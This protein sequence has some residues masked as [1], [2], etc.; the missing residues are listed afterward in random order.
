MPSN[1]LIESSPPQGVLI[2]WIVRGAVVSIL[3]ITLG[4]GKPFNVKQQPELPPVSYAARAST[5][6]VSIQ[7]QAIADEDFLYDTFD[8]NLISAGVLP[9]RVMLT[10]SVDHAVDLQKARFEM[11]AP[12]HRFQQAG[13]RQAFKRLISYYE[14]SVYNKS[15]YKKSLDAFSAYAI[16][17]KTP[18][19]AGQSRQGLVF[20]LTTSESARG[21]GLTLVVSRLSSNASR[22]RGTVELRLN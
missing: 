16:D 18:L 2:R 7:A 8:A 9:V 14:I 21:M 11:R 17:V 6:G 3:A 1:P 20:F 13:A 5:D 22:E 19:A 15:G 12:G 4:C 10:N